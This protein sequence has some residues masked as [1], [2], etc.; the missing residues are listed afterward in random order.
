[1]IEPKDIETLSEYFVRKD[2]CTANQ[3][4]LEL[5]VA[6]IGTTLAVIQSQLK[7]IQWVGGTI[8]AAVLGIAV[9]FV[10]GG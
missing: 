4:E 1:M 8:G 3:K 10:F 5:N 9:K 2:E 6:N 7:F